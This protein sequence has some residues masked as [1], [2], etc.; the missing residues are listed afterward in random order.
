M[1]IVRL[2]GRVEGKQDKNRK[3]R[4]KLLYR[5]FDAGWD[6]YNGNGD[7]VI[8][9]DNIQEKIAESDAFVFMPGATLEDMFN[10]SSIFVGFQTNDG[11]LMGKPAVILNS[12]QS[13]GSFLAL[14]EHLHNMG[15]VK[16]HYSDFLT[17]VDKPK[18]VLP[19]LEES[20]PTK[21]VVRSEEPDIFTEGNGVKDGI[22]KPEFN[23]CVFCSSG[24]KKKDYLEEGYNLGKSLAK[25]GWGCISG[26]GKTGVMGSVVKG[27]IENGGW[28]AGSNVPH[29]VEMEGLP[30]GLNVFWPRGDIYTRMEVMIKESDCFVIMPGGLG[31][32]Q[33]LLA[34]IIL[35]QQGHD[36]TKDKNIIVVNRKEGENGFWAPMLDIIEQYKALDTLHVVDSFSDS[37][38][39][40]KDLHSLV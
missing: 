11:E 1:P 36:M 8:T 37:I 16:Q 24:I 5:L 31:T 13:W 14:I 9:L 23:V 22:K 30:E 40:I 18:K 21:S 17:I 2:S 39:K 19:I 7:Q 20:F 4:A 28:A 12:D 35:K 32:V 38:K 6:I 3:T 26:A 25:N 10:A 34:L 33:E 27:A 15:T 29:I